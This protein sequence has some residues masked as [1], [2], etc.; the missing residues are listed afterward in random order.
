MYA[1]DT[2]IFLKY[3]SYESLHFVSY[4]TALNIEKWLGCN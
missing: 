3:K 2:K 1:D 4:L